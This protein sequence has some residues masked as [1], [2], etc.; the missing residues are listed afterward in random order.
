MQ[1]IYQWMGAI[2]MAVFLVAPLLVPLWLQRF[3]WFGVVA[4]SYIFYLMGILYLRFTSGD[5][6]FETGYGRFI[7]YYL[8]AVSLAGYLLQKLADRREEKDP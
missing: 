8:I 4:I 3:V 7:L 2:Q 5:A 1:N 6:E